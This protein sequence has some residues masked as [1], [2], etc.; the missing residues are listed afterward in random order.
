[1]RGIAIGLL[2]LG[3]SAAFAHPPLEE[4]LELVEREITRSPRD[5]GLVLERAELRREQGDTEAAL[6]DYARAE[7]LDPGLA[8]VDL[9]R[10]RLFLALGRPAEAEA[11]LD[12]YLG[13][14]QDDPEGYLLRARAQSRLHR[15]REAAR[16]YDR[17]LRKAPA[18]APDLYLERARMLEQAGE[19]RAAV[20]GLEAGMERL[21]AL[22]VLER[23][24]ARLAARAGGRRRPPRLGRHSGAPELAP[25]PAP[26]PATPPSARAT[27]G[28][29][30][31]LGTPTSVIVRW[32]TDFAAPS[33][34]DYRAAAGG[35]VYRVG[36]EALATYHQVTLPGLSPASAYFYALPDARL[37]TGLGSAA[38]EIPFHT[39]PEAGAD[40]PVRIWAVGDSGTANA[41]ARAVRDG[42][43]AFS[44]GH[45]ADLWLMLGDNAYPRGTDDQYQAAVFDTYTEE[46]ATSVLWPTLGNHDGLSASSEL[47][48]GPYFTAF[49]LPRAGEAGGLPSGT[50]AYYSFDYG[51]IH[52]VCLDS[53]DL[54][55]SPQGAMLTWLAADLAA[56]HQPWIIAY[57]HHPPYSKGSHDSDT[58][59]RLAEMRE[60]ALPILERYGVDLVLGGHSHAYERSVLLDSHYGPS[61]TL[62]PGMVLDGGDGDPAGDGAYEKPSERGGHEGAVYAVDGS[63]AKIGGG[64]LDHPAMRVS[65]RELGSLV[66]DV[67]GRRLDGRFLDTTG[68][69]ADRFTL[70]QGPPAPPPPPAQLLTDSDFPDFRFGIAITGQGSAT[71]LGAS[72]PGCLPE[73]LCVS[74]ALPGRTE[75]MVRIVGPKPNGYLWPSIVKLSTSQVEVWIEQVSTGLLRYY[76]LP[77]ASP[78][79]DTL[80]GLFDRH[81]FLPPE[82]LTARPP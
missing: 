8:E 6:A 60:N 21:G 82:N 13:R 15:T 70:V 23:E 10:A 48:T 66:L 33:R 41:D 80:P 32:R 72:E 3:A 14:R 17:A 5:A 57:W 64:P 29:Y 76:L 9:G 1:M 42:Y 39:S 37:P 58:E 69:V 65:L 11:R 79:D 75:V 78:G 74:G 44:A 25:V 56:T 81:G 27:R 40:V 20:R 31:Q 7:A 28:P 50:E 22:T 68:A 19:T 67:D 26:T 47:G 18:P 63:S 55:R 53:Y 36:S 54:D 51:P 61:T 59:A 45:P 43:R 73:T 34:V 2:V 24:A 71:T 16:D 62:A 49:T 77:A 46:L 38:G 30:L 52:F 4:R 12:R 35:P